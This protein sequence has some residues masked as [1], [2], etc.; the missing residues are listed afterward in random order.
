MKKIINS[1]V[2]IL[3]VIIICIAIFFIISN[4]INSEDSLLIIRGSSPISKI[5]MEIITFPGLNEKKAITISDKNLLD[6]FSISLQNEI[7]PVQM[8]VAKAN[9]V[10]V[11]L[12]VYKGAKKIRMEVVNSE[13]T[14]W[15]L[16]I[17]DSNFTDEFIF[18]TIKKNLK[19]EGE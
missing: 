11:I 15:V 1:I 10:Y 8:Q 5:E 4:H 9:N 16:I 7:K 14:G 3:F 13:Y 6:S 18:R 17:G 12:E 2:S 19:K